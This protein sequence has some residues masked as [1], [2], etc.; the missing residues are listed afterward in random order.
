MD[1]P[2]SRTGGSGW[3]LPNLPVDFAE[4]S[5]AQGAEIGS[6]VIIYVSKIIVY[7]TH[8]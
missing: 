4:R 5:A 8:P 1:L 7:G 3:P 6:R 2:M